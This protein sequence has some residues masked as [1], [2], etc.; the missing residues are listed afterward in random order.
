M[1]RL[2]KQSPGALLPADE[3]RTQATPGRDP[4]LGADRRADRPVLRREGG[5][6]AMKGIRRFLIRLA[7]AVTQSADEQR[8]RE[9]L[10]QHVALQ[11]A[12]NIRAGVPAAEA[13]RLA[14]R[15]LG[16]VESIKEDYRNERS[17]PA[18]DTLRQDLRYALRQLRKAPLFTFTA[19][20][21]LGMGIGANTAVFTIVERVLFR[22]LPVSSPHELVYVTDQRILQEQSPRFSYPFY[23]A[24]RDNAVLNGVAARAALAVTAAAN[25]EVARI[26]GELVSGEYFTLL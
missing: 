3:C 11:T 8:L 18:L 13:R 25:G 21:S 2:G 5:G 19:T 23:Q 20:V 26:S 1:G 7:A 17:L 15:K 22:S 24:L 10:E 16:S 4:R 12:E 6:P 9:E 14:L